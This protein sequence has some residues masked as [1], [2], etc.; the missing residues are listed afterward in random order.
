MQEPTQLDR[1]EAQNKEILAQLALVLEKSGK[2]KRAT[3]IDADFRARM[4]AEFEVLGDQ[5][6]VD[7]QIDLA[8][9]H[10]GYDKY[11]DK[12]M[13][14]KNWLKNTVT[15]NAERPGPLKP[16][17]RSYQD[18]SKYEADYQRRWGG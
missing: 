6:A 8:V 1:I 2:R 12:Q 17:I 14:V 3:V 15:F 7:H 18:R 9:A 16:N 11:T 13:Y 10:K 4:V 5:K